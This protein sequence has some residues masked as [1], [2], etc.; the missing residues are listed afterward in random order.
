MS[1]FIFYLQSTPSVSLTVPKGPGSNHPDIWKEPP[2]GLLRATLL[3][4]ADPTCPE[5]PPIGQLTLDM[6]LLRLPAWSGPLSM[7]LCGNKSWSLPKGRK[8]GFPQGEPGQ[9]RGMAPTD[10]GQPPLPQRWPVMRPGNNHPRGHLTCPEG[11]QDFP[12]PAHDL[13]QHPTPLGL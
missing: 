3:Q 7:R 10:R 13:E 12:E 6:F 4:G 11:G 9:G 8:E 1:Y 2:R 5:G